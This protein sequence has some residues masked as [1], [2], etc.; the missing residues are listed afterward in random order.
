[1]SAMEELDIGM[2]QVGHS[3]TG[4]MEYTTAGINVLSCRTYNTGKHVCWDKS[5]E[6]VIKRFT[7]DAYKIYFESC[8]T[9][10]SSFVRWMLGNGH[11]VITL[12]QGN[13][14]VG[15]STSYEKGFFGLWDLWINEQGIANL[16]SIPKLEKDGYVIDYNTNRDWVVPTP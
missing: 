3:D 7:L 14:N 4:V 8:A 15:A 16:L 9:Y 6:R 12:I 1:M 11:Q 5:T 13:C 10:H 2:V